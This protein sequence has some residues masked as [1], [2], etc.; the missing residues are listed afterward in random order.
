ML[1]EVGVYKASEGF[2]LA[3]A[4]AEGMVTTSVNEANS[5]TF[6][7]GWNPTRQ[8]ASISTDRIPGPIELAQALLISSTEQKYT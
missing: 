8:A 6:S 3:G 5:F 4:A 2:Q 1:S 7:T